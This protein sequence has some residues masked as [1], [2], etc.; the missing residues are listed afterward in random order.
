MSAPHML[1]SIYQHPMCQIHR[2]FFRL[3]LSRLL[4][5]GGRFLRFAQGYEGE[6][7]A[8]WNQY[9]EHGG[10]DGEEC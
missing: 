7:D 3:F 9:G 10:E 2:E 5:L 4:L 1:L 6:Y 8:A